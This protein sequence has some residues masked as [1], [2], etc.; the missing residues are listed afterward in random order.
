MVFLG[1]S[2]ES[3]LPWG[4]WFGRQWRLLKLSYSEVGHSWPGEGREEG[5]WHP[6]CWRTVALKWVEGGSGPC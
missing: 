2:L 4:W 3:G 1:A 6:G 5:S